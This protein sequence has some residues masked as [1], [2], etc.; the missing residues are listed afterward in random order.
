VAGRAII[1]VTPTVEEVA[2]LFPQVEILG[3]LGKG[4]TG[5]YASDRG[6]GRAAGGAPSLARETLAPLMPAA[7]P[8]FVT[9]LVDG[10]NLRQL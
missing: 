2:R 3:F 9:E 6:T 10:V 7:L 1:P 8:Y 4:G 5:L